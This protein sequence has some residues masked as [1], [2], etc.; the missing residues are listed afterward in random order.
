MKLVLLALVILLSGCQFGPEPMALYWHN[1]GD[2]QLNLWQQDSQILLSTTTDY[3]AGNAELDAVQQEWQNVFA[4]WSRINAFPYKG[5]ADLTLEFELYFWPDRRNRIEG[6]LRQ[7]LSAGDSANPQLLETRIAA[8]K[9][10]AAIEWLVFAADTDRASRCQMLAGT[11]EDYDNKVAMVADYHQQNPVV[12]P[13]W[14]SADNPAQSNSIALNLLFSQ[15]TALTSR[16]AN[17][18]DAESHWLADQAYGW[19][20]GSTLAGFTASL[21]SLLEHLDYLVARPELAHETHQQ[22]LEL[23]SQGREL[24]QNMP[25]SQMTDASTAAAD[26]LV[27]LGELESLLQGHISHDFNVLIGFNNFDGD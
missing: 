27:W 15:L 20:S 17:S 18:V 21:D 22:L 16:L 13:D 14:L 24:S 23:M 2:T 4:R 10:L 5:I 25:A 6:Q 26:L 3:C 8:E 7:R 1:W 19:R 9:G 12:H 11:A